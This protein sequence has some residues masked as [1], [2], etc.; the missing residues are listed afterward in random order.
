VAGALLV[1]D[2][3]VTDRGRGHE[4]VV[5]RQDGTAR[6]AEDVPDAEVLE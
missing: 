5:E 6:Q 3:D 2:E 4:L 1:T